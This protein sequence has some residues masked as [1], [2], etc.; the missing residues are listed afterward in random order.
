MNSI[1]LTQDCCYEKL[2]LIRG[3]LDLG[4]FISIMFIVSS[5]LPWHVFA[6]VD[7]APPTSDF[8]QCH[9]SCKLKRSYAN[10]VLF[11]I[12]PFKFLVC[13]TYTKHTDTID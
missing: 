1:N 5:M 12:S 4:M 11:I 9:R 6:H 3:H 13:K 10:Q 2:T 8:T 7:M